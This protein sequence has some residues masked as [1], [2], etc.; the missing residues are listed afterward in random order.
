MEQLMKIAENEKVIVEYFKSTRSFRGFYCHEQGCPPIIG[1]SIALH[2]N[3][4]LHR[5]VMAEELGHHFTSVCDK[6]AF[7][8]YSPQERLTIDK[9]EYKALKW[10]ANHLV[11]ENDLLDAIREGLFEVWELAEHFDITEDMMRFR[12]R[13]FGV[14]QDSI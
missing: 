7:K 6:S 10:A 12:M 3:Y 11:P 8:R 9:I 14:R 4:R 5:C 1:L 2:S 13:L